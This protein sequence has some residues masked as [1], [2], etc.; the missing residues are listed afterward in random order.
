MKSAI[1]CGL[2][3]F[4]FMMALTLGVAF[5]DKEI[6]TTETTNVTGNE[7]TEN[8]SQNI[9]ATENVTESSS[10]VVAVNNSIIK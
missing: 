2:I 7:T 6:A 9:N 3:L 10:P 5:A 8:V 1:K 4:S